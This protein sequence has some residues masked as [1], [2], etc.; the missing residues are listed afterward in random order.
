M[1]ILT[2]IVVPLLLAGAACHDGS[3][4]TGG[5]VFDATGTWSVEVVTTGPPPPGCTIVDGSAVGLPTI[6]G[7]VELAASGHPIVVDQANSR[8][9]MRPIEYVD[10]AVTH[11]WALDGTVG[12][13]GVEA[14]LT[15]VVKL[16]H[17][18]PALAAI[19]VER[20]SG[21]SLSP[22]RLLL[23]GDGVAFVPDPAAA[24]LEVCSAAPT[25]TYRVSAL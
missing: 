18:S 23:T 8:I 6:G 3:G 2:A 11:R 12:A 24:E 7:L 16:Q 21:I 4:T 15:H 13:P 1:R 14:R 5:G 9:T 19:G 10:G 20:L 22:R 25:A 17:S